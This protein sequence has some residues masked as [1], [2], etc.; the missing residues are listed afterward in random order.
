VPLIL[1]VLGGFGVRISA[2]AKLSGDN[3][4]ANALPNKKKLNKRIIIGNR[5]FWGHLEVLK[6][7]IEH[8]FT[9]TISPQKKTN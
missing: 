7:L 2:F 5:Y 8:T 6:F 3:V 1:G 9:T 4:K